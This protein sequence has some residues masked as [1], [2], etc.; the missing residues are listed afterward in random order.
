MKLEAAPA[1]RA[2][3]HTVYRLKDGTKVPGV[4]TILNA[5]INKPALIKWANQ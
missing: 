1:R 2:K 5:T 3:V 4:T